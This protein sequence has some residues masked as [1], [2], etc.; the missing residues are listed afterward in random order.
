MSDALDPAAAM[1]FIKAHQPRLD[2]D[3]IFAVVSEMDRPPDREGEPLA[4]QLLSITN[5]EISDGD[6]KK[7]LAEWRAFAAL[8]DERDWDDDELDYVNRFDE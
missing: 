7:I 3:H 5:P 6:V 8:A 1:D 2:E 4:L